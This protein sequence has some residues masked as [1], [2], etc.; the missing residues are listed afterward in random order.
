[1]VAREVFFLSADGSELYDAFRFGLLE[2]LIPLFA[3]D[4]RGF[5]RDRLN[6]DMIKKVASVLLSGTPELASQDKSIVSEF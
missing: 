3:R 1:M 6:E 2:V 4:D 5:A